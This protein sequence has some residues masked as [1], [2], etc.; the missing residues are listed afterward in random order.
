MFVKINPVNTNSNDFVSIHW[1]EIG[2]S[3]FDM[4]EASQ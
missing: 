2:N 1:L 3:L 4:L